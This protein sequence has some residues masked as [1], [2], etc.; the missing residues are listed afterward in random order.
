[1]SDRGSSGP[2]SARGALVCAVLALVLAFALR[3]WGVGF[4]LPAAIE[5][6]SGV[7]VRQVEMLRDATPAA[8]RDENWGS[9]PHLVAH[10]AAPFAPDD[11]PRAE[12]DTVEE[13][14]TRAGL[15]HRHVRWTVLLLSLLA[16]PFAYLVA[17]RF[18]RARG[19][20][21]AS[22]LVA[23]SLLFQTFA[24]EARPHAAAAA[25]MLVALHACLV[26][27]ERGT[28]GAF[29]WAG[30]AAGLAVGTLQDDVLVL[31][32]LGLACVFAGRPRGTA[33]RAPIAR[34]MLGAIV[35]LAL[36]A[37]CAWVLYPRGG[38][39]HAG[40]I[41]AV[42]AVHKTL[43]FFGHNVVLGEF[44]GSGFA[45][46]FWSLWSFEPLACVLALV[47]LG[48]WLVRVRG[49]VLD[50][51]WFGDPRL[52][53]LVA[54]FVLHLVAIGMYARSYERFCLQLVPLVAVLA[55]FGAERIVERAPRARFVVAGAWIVFAL[56]PAAR[57]TLLR[58]GGIAQDEAG[59]WLA[60]HARK[61]E[62]ILLHRLVDVPLLR[63][64]DALASDARRF[65][66]PHRGYTPW[67]RYQA[68]VADDV[69]RDAR[70]DVRPA[71]LVRP[72]DQAAFERDPAAWLAASGA[73]Y[74]V[75]PLQALRE[76]P[77]LGRALR[78][79]CREHGELA[80]RFPARA[81]GE[82]DVV[83]GYEDRVE[84]A[85]PHWTWSLLARDPI[86]VEVVEVWR[87]R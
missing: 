46:A 5:D 35:A 72:E 56:V 75:L 12:D 87:I 3:A 51:D 73:R 71:A 18:V 54:Y 2:G 59:A 31:V 17:R 63:T 4:A 60:A 53:L 41:V 39:A 33:E 66:M 14:L 6:D 42:D 67:R 55:A 21:L 20:V 79:A 15:V 48:A 29:S 62:R 37:A 34:T 30:L 50:H 28:L 8:E 69:A 38:D 22:A 61:D 25:V 10:L 81:D 83:L 23:T 82:T 57:F 9:Y 65:T 45:I 13:L 7:L 24:Q 11:A 19:A 47:G 80:A 86:S 78:R 16:V 44:D 32:P 70:F 68:R 77:E 64:P 40:P 84:S 49:R 52:F 26:L 58:A 74:V 85:R 1:M 76:G 36:A 43:R 27:V